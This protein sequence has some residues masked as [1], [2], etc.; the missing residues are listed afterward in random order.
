MS[1]KKKKISVLRAER[2]N[3]RRRLRNLMW[4][5]RFKYLLR[6]FKKA[7]SL[8]EKMEWARKLQSTLDKIGQRR[9]FHPNKAA[10]LKSKIMKELA[11]I[12]QNG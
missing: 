10:R 12:S 8:E 5:T 1:K 11:K 7:E 9:I 6:K 3:E 2:R 4:K